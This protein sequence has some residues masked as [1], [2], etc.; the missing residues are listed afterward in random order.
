[1]HYHFR[2]IITIKASGNYYYWKNN[3]SNMPVYD[4]P[5][6]DAHL[7]ID[8][9]I[10]QKWSLY[11]ENSFEGKRLARTNIND[12]TLPML[13]DLNL[14]AQYNINRWLHVYLQL[15]NYLHRQ[16]SIY[17]GYNTQGCHFLAGVKYI[18]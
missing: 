2:D 16:N 5:N 10:S 17:Y 14:G 9:H 8:A 4:R 1:M 3:V 18:F 15:G 12:E 11:S 13:I 7:R 6:W